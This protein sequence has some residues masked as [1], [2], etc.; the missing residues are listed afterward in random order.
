MVRACLLTF[1]A[2]TLAMM[3]T[4][5]GLEGALFGPVTDQGHTIL[6]E[7]RDTIFVAQA[8]GLGGATTTLYTSGATVPDGGETLVEVTDGVEGRISFALPGTLSAA[9]AVL[10]VESP[11]AI[12]AGVIPEIPAAASVFH[13][14]RVVRAWEQHP[15]LADLDGYTTAAAFMAFIAIAGSLP[16]MGGQC[17]RSS[18][19]G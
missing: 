11:V 4:G 19:D 1:F 16:Q 10:W 6:P 9:G 18:Q 2:A 13:E 5:C 15:S 14:S 7:P 8:S 17:S 12:A 3:S